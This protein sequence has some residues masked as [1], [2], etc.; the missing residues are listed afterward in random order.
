MELKYNISQLGIISADLFDNAKKCY[1]FLHD[2]KYVAKIEE[3]NQLGV[4]QN[5]PLRT[6]HKRM[7]YVVLQI[8]LVNLLLGRDIELNQYRGKKKKFNLGLSNKET[9]NSF[10][11]SGA[12]LIIIWILLFNSGH[13]MGTFAAEKGLLKCIAMNNLLYEKFENNMP[14][15]IKNDF[16]ECINRGDVYNLHKFLIIF[17]LTIHH[18]QSRSPK[19]KKFINFLIEI[20]Q[21]Y[22]S[23][24]NEK[25]LKFKRY[26][27]K[28]RQIS[29]L[30]LDSQYSEFPLNFKITPLLLNLDDYLD[31]ILDENSYFN[32]ALDSLD[33]LLSHNVYYS[34]ESISEFNY[35]VTKFENYLKNKFLDENQIKNKIIVGFPLLSKHEPIKSLHLILENDAETKNFYHDKFDIGLENYLNDSLPENCRISIENVEKFNFIIINVIFISGNYYNH[36]ISISKLTKELIRIKNEI[37]GENKL[38]GDKFNL[39]QKE[40]SE[41]FKEIMQFILNSIIKT[42]YFVFEDSYDSV[43]IIAPHTKDNI[44]AVFDNVLKHNLEKFKE[45]EKLLIRKIGTNLFYNNST[46]LLS[47]SSIKGYLKDTDRLDVEIDGLIMMYKKQKLHLYLIESKVMMKGAFKHANDDLSK[48]IDKLGLDDKIFEIKQE[49]EPKGLYYQLIIDSNC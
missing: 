48:K 32:K 25:H 46:M 4:L 49:F 41:V 16:R 2:K 37:I 31:E 43:Q 14:D 34:K 21:I 5:T 24:E 38:T 12:D 26:F 42:H 23:S 28:I 44:D 7:E 8:Y 29:Y 40:F 47:L 30:F 13:L 9:L 45:N 22:F 15:N 3:M 20:C 18:K 39:I 27:N 17:T 35:Y 36:L 6:V 11:I 10:K 19:S 1:N 33:G